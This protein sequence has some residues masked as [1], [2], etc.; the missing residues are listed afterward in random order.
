MKIKK[1]LDPDIQQKLKMNLFKKYGYS[2]KQS[3]VDFSKFNEDFRRI[4][5]V[6]KP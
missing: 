6:G 3:I 1:N 2:I 4:G 5:L